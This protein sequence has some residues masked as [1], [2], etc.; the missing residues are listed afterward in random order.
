MQGV[1]DGE[2]VATA[3]QWL[4]SGSGKQQWRR[5]SITAFKRLADHETSTAALRSSSSFPRMKA[6]GASGV[7]SQTSDGHS[8]SD[9]QIPAAGR[10]FFSC[11]LSNYWQACAALYFHA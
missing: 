4:C 1:D 6:I 7:K 8:E 9:L 11:S 10:A 3:V 2:E 5:T